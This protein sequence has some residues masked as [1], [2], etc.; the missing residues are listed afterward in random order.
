MLIA[1]RSS[2]LRAFCCCAMVIALATG[3]FHRGAMADNLSQ[4]ER[5]Y[6]GAVVLWVS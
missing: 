3:G 1:A 4:S 5:F 6:L 2:K